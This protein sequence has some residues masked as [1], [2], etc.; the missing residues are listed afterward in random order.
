MKSLTLLTLGLLSAAFLSGCATQKTVNGRV[1]NIGA[2]LVKVQTGSYQPSKAH[3]LD[4]DTNQIVGNSASTSG[5][6]TTLLW[7]LLSF[8]AY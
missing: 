8:N 3:T 5:T 2:G 7:G 4:V 6:E 1:T